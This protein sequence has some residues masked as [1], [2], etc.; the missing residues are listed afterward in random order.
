MR[1]NKKLLSTVVASALVATTMAV[2]AMAGDGDTTGIGVINQTAGMKVIVS[3]FFAN[4]NC[5]V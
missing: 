1:R 3:T 4:T 5:P 2:P